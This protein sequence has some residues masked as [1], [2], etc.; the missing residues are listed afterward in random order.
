MQMRGLWSWVTSSGPRMLC[1]A[2][3]PL[4]LRSHLKMQLRPRNARLPTA[5]I[6]FHPVLLKPERGRVTRVVFNDMITQH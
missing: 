5:K 3:L 6:L 2:Y 4:S 1:C